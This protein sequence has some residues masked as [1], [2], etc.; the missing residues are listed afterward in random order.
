MEKEKKKGTGGFFI[1]SRVRKQRVCFF[2]VKM[3]KEEKTWRRRQQ[4]EAAMTTK[5][6]LLPFSFVFAFFQFLGDPS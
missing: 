3:K 2:R 1:F 4:R 6:W 5:D